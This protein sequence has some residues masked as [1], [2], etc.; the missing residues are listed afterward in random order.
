MIN[1]R[2]SEMAKPIKKIP[3]SVQADKD[4][5][6]ALE[7]IEELNE[8]IY[9]LELK[10]EESIKFSNLTTNTINYILASLYV[11][12]SYFTEMGIDFNQM[13]KQIDKVFY[14]AFNKKG[15]KKNKPEYHSNIIKKVNDRLREFQEKVNLDKVNK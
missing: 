7:L 2:S 4:L 9:K 5:I 6:A 3:K 12:E 13:K 10:T 15:V 14:E 1:L 8:R 11:Y